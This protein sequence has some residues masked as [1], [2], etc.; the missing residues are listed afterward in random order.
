MVD[1]ELFET[2]EGLAGVQGIVHG[3]T[4][5]RAEVDVCAER[6]VALERLDGHL[7]AGVA[8]LGFGWDQLVTGEQVHGAEVEDIAFAREVE[9]GIEG[10][11][12][13]VTARSDVLLG[14]YVADCAAVYLVDRREGVIGLAHSGRR[15]TELGIV[16]RTLETMGACYGTRPKDVRV[17]ISPCIRPP[18]YEVDFASEIRRQCVAAGV[19]QGEI[20]DDRVSTACDLERYYSYRLEKGRTGRMLAMMGIAGTVD[21]GG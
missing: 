2:F 20:Y 7:R 11:D 13:L 19:E 8:G 9:Q 17:Q 10:V 15:G 4:L 5:R 12:A 6:A 18:D 14:V 16:S 1:E 21:R 3:F